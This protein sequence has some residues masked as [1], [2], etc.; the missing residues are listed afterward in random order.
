MRTLTSTTLSACAVGVALV[1]GSAVPAHASTPTPHTVTR[2]SS[3]TATA[4]TAPEFTV[5]TYGGTDKGS[6]AGLRFAG[7]AKPGALVIVYYD[8]PGRAH[9]PLTLHIAQV[10]DGDPDVSAHGNFSF[11]ADFPDLPRGTTTLRWH[12]RLVDPDTLSV[13]ARI[14]GERAL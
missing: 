9:G 2:A 8:A 14:N 6:F 3:V 11:T 13:I 7:T 1:V 5:R 4:S 10:R 12:A